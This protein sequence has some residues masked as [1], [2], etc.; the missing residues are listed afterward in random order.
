MK[1]SRHHVATLHDL[2]ASAIA[3]WLALYLR[4]GA[5]VLLMP[6]RQT[7]LAFV[8]FMTTCGVSY[9]SFGLYRGVWRY[10]S[11]HD[12]TQILRA[13]VCSILVF[14]ALSFVAFRADAVPRS[15]PLI[16]LFV[17]PCL[18]AGS[19][20]FYRILREQ[21]LLRL[22]PHRGEAVLL[23]GAGDEAELFIRTAGTRANAAFRI[24]GMLDDR[25]GRV[26]GMIHH[27]KVLGHAGRSGS[28]RDAPARRRPRPAPHRADTRARRLSL[29]ALAQSD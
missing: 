2:L 23:L 1:F 24:L 10:A 21:R 15:L 22:W 14:V 5:D 18:L 8:L 7:S 19:R 17:L 9:Y 25:G 16:L 3:F 11:L 29:D 28:S 13:T 6:M 27:V 4:I 20:V 12:A 26:G